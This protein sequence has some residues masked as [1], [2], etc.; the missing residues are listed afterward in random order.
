MMAA[1]WAAQEAIEHM[2]VPEQQAE[3]KALMAAQRLRG[4]VAISPNGLNGTLSV[5]VRTDA[6]PS[7]WAQDLAAALQDVQT[8]VDCVKALDRIEEARELHAITRTESG[9]LLAAAG[10]I[11]VA[12][13]WL[14]E[15]GRRDLEGLLRQRLGPGPRA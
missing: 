11:A 15:D 13:G 9:R 7:P 14:G 3:Q 1:R 5:D 4:D 12:H 6:N 8:E 2:S 10:G